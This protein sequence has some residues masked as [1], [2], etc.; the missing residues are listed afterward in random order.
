MGTD[1]NSKKDMK[2]KMKKNNS[3][4]DSPVTTVQV[5]CHTSDAPALMDQDSADNRDR[6]YRTSA[7]HNTVLLLL[8]SVPSVALMWRA[9]VCGDLRKCCDSDQVLLKGLS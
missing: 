5:V 4:T 8:T 7:L 6:T 9:I 2:K 1:D 3:Q